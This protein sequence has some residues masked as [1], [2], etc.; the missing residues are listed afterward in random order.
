ML[1]FYNFVFNFNPNNDSPP[2][3]TRIRLKFSLYLSQ[4]HLGFT[5]FSIFVL[6]GIFVKKIS[7]FMAIR[8]FFFF[9]LGFEYW[10]LVIKLCFF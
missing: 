1:L 2:F 5:D 8:F 7:F 4:L 10:K 6:V 3:G 9:F